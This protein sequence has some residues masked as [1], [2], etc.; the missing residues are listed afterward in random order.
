MQNHKAGPVYE[1]PQNPMCLPP[2]DAHAQETEVLDGG[3]PLQQRMPVRIQSG[4]GPNKK[5]VKGVL[6]I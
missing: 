4:E 1:T 3:L 6:V 5:G 2:T